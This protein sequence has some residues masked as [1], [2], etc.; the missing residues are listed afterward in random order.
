[1]RGGR[2]GLAEP[3]RREME[4]S[5][6]RAGDGIGF[7][8][9]KAGGSVSEEILRGEEAEVGG[10]EGVFGSGESFCLLEVI[11]VGRCWEVI[12]FSLLGKSTGFRSLEFTWGDG[13]VAGMSL[14]VRM[15]MSVVLQAQ[16]CAKAISTARWRR[17]RR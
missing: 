8:A 1:M 12:S 6:V 9:L 7:M 13:E 15:L 4:L 3:I 11:C 14:G 16:S 10:W 17:R 5:S 2:Y